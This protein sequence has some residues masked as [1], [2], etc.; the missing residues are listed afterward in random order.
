MNIKDLDIR[1]IRSKLG[2]TQKQLA[3]K[4]GV[5]PNTIQNWEYGGAIPKTRR[6][7]LCSLIEQSKA[8][9]DEQSFHGG[10]QYNQHGDNIKGEHVT[11]K[12]SDIDKF[13]DAINKA[14]TISLQSQEQINELLAQNKEQ[15]AR[16]MSLLEKMQDK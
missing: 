2:M 6:Q 13:L 14:Q 10:D 1:A 5:S 4:L 16:L 15:F 12:S 7:I 8:S 3:E 11:V 9:I